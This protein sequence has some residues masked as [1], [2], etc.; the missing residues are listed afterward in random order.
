MGYITKRSTLAQEV[1]R[2]MANTCTNTIQARRLAVLEQFIT[3]LRVS[4]FNL[5]QM[6]KILVAGMTGY[7]RR[8]TLAQ[9][10]GTSHHRDLQGKAGE[11]RLKKLSLKQEWFLTKLDKDKHR[12][13]STGRRKNPPNK[14]VDVLSCKQPW[15]VLFVTR[16]PDRKLAA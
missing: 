13:D 15:S 1:I 8:L 4:G 11:R 14:Q 12:G 16:S 5:Q 7:K 6:W 9:N 10:K 3:R 2:M